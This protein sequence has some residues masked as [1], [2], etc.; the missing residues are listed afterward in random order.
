[1][2]IS[3]LTDGKRAKTVVYENNGR[4]FSEPDFARLRKIAEGNP[5]EQ[6]IGFFGVGFYSLFSICEEPL[7]VLSGA[8]SLTLTFSSVTSGNQS[9]AFL[10]KGDMLYTK[11]GIIPPESITEW[12]GFYLN[13]RE[14][15]DVPDAIEFGTFLAT[16]M[17]FTSNIRQIEVY[18]DSERTHWYDKKV[19]ESRPLP[20]A[21]GEYTLSSPTTLLKLESVSMRNIQVSAC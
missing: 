15:L 11:K 1:M 12:T 17:A 3:F 6:K 2:K 19:S 7:Y 18:R 20:F 9:M 21:L 14:P 16:S 10:W 5:D 4:P 13:M 8:F